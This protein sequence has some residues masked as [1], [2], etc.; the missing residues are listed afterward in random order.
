MD[1][2]MD[3]SKGLVRA[4]NILEQNFSITPQETPKVQPPAKPTEFATPSLASST[5]ENTV[6]PA[7]RVRPP[8]NSRGA[9]PRPPD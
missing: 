5:L 2:R 6:C 4:G 8:Q 9:A 7:W 3:D 1:K